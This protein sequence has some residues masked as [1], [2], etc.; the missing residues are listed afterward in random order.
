MFDTPAL[1]I[2]SVYLSNMA[3]VLVVV[4]LLALVALLLYGIPRAIR[5]ARR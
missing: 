4:L 5:E 2:D 1:Y 3:L